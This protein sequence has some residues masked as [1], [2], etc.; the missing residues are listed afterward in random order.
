MGGSRGW[1]QHGEGT[2]SWLPSQ[3]PF[4][5]EG[6]W[7]CSSPHIPAAATPFQP[8]L[9]GSHEFPGCA[10]ARFPEPNPRILRGSES[11]ERDPSLNAQKPTS[12]QHVHM[13]AHLHLDTRTYTQ[14]HP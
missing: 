1:G 7:G 10:R 9:T 8:V 3:R 4:L 6:G 12:L 5:H 14:K 11:N 2:G 13:H